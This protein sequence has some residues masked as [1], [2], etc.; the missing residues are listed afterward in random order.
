M[1]DIEGGHWYLPD[2]TLMA[3]VPYA[4]K[5]RAGQSRPTTLRDARKLGLYPSVTTVLAT[6]DRPGLRKWKLEWAIEL[7]LKMPNP[8]IAD[9][10]TEADAYVEY[11]ATQ[12]SKIHLGLSE[13]LQ[14]RTIEIEPEVDDV[15]REFMPWYRANGLVIHRSERP[16][17]SPLG[18]A[19]TIDYEGTY[20]GKPCVLDFKTQD[21]DGDTKRALFYDEHALQLAGYD[22][23]LNDG[24]DRLRLSVILSR[25]VP[26]LIALHN[27]SEKPGENRRWSR[28]W[29]TLWEFWQHLHN[30]YPCLMEDPDNAGGAA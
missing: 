29:L 20:Y 2:G 7:A 19:G 1:A 17:V 11:A 8:S 27:W 9:V 21:Y 13:T 24:V 6:L 25:Q 16:V 12:G 14:G 10:V 30:Y 4:D 15:V 28:A 3:E 26:G 18:Y 23:A 22:E 5:K